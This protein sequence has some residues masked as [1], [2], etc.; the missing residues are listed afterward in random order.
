MR[1]DKVLFTVFKSWLCLNFLA[2]ALI[3]QLSS[4][5]YTVINAPQL[6]NQCISEKIE[7]RKLSS[8]SG[9]DLSLLHIFDAISFK[10]G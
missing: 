9:Y 10:F 3:H 1:T 6:L 7:A 5:Y 4:I 8:R 2:N